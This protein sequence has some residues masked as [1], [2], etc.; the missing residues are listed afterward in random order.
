M[1]NITE[2]PV[3]DIGHKPLSSSHNIN[4]AICI[5]TYLTIGS[6]FTII[7]VIFPGFSRYL[8]RRDIGHVY[9]PILPFDGIIITNPVHAKRIYTGLVKSSA[10][11]VRRNFRLDG[12]WRHPIPS[13]YSGSRVFH[14]TYS[15]K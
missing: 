11:T 5:F 12:Q 6:F 2:L 14:T 4:L 3:C 13:E 10:A 7:G 1:I 8:V 15:I 9:Y